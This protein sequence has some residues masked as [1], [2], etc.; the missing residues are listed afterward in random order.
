MVTLY[1]RWY[2]YLPPPLYHDK[3]IYYTGVRYLFMNSLYLDKDCP[4]DHTDYDHVVEKKQD[5]LIIADIKNHIMCDHNYHMVIT[6]YQGYRILVPLRPTGTTRTIG[7]MGTTRT[8][9][10]MR[11]TGTMVFD[12]SNFG[13]TNLVGL[14]VRNL[15]YCVLLLNINMTIP[16]CRRFCCLS[17]R[18]DFL[19]HNIFSCGSNSIYSPF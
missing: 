6:D 11:T 12:K 14:E 17:N 9:G 15:T 10:T 1:Y 7:T 2:K 13:Q 18:G 19:S 4:V 8:M 3:G 5:L 16:F